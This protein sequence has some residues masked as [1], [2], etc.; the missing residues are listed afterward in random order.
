MNLL[1]CSIR[2]SVV[3]LANFEAVA[4]AMVDPLTR[5]AVPAADVLRS[6]L[7][8]ALADLTTELQPNQ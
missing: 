1:P 2:L 3:D 7:R 4:A 6:A 5:P 8:L